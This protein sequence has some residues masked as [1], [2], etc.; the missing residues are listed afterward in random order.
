MALKADE[1]AI[2]FISL[3]LGHRFWL[4]AVLALLGLLLLLG[5]VALG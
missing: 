5:L 2:I 3:L 4:A 1:A